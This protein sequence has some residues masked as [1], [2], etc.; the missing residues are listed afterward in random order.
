MQPSHL[1]QVW[2]LLNAH[3]ITLKVS[4]L[5]GEGVCGLRCSITLCSPTHTIIVLVISNTIHDGMQDGT[6]T[7]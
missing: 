7:I 6:I 4:F 1:P 2:C 3:Q 5:G